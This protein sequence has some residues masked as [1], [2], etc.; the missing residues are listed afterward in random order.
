MA[1]KAYS[2]LVL[3]VG[4]SLTLL[5]ADAAPADVAAENPTLV[6]YQGA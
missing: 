1:M 5:A 2:L 3:T 4:G 6:V